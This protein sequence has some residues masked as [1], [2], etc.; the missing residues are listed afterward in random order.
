MA[1]F[2]ML[3]K[4]I[5]SPVG[6]RTAQVWAMKLSTKFALL[7]QMSSEFFRGSQSF[8]ALIASITKIVGLDIVVDRAFIEQTALA[9]LF[10]Y[11]W[12]IELALC[13]LFVCE[14]S[15]SVSLL[16]LVD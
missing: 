15:E 2:V 11:L 1:V 16:S 8:M 7:F 3:A 12:S 13:E 14:R 6:L 10:W 9:S 4:M 5:F